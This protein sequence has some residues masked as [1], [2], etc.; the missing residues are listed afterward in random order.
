MPVIWVSSVSG[1][2]EVTNSS[3]QSLHC[4]EEEVEEAQCQTEVRRLRVWGPSVCMKN[5]KL[6]KK[7]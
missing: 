3:V 6:K 4:N 5:W 1:P 2:V 7:K